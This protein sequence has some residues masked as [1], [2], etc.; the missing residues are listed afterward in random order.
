MSASAME[1]RVTALE[2]KVERLLGADGEQETQETPWY[3][4]RLGAFKDNPIYD[5]AMRRGEEYRKAQPNPFDN[6]DALEF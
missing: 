2:E 5:S 4:L 6:P 1:E 3:M